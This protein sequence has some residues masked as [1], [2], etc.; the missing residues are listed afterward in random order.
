MNLGILYIFFSLKS[1]SDTHLNEDTNPTEGP[2]ASKKAA[3]DRTVLADKKKPV[4]KD[5]KR[6]LKRL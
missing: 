3:T 6:T 1:N 5:K 4:A 2:T